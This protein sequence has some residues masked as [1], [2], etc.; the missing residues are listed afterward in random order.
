MGESINLNKLINSGVHLGHKTSRWNPKML[1][2]IFTEKNKSHIIDL[3]QTVK[4]LKKAK[5][6]LQRASRENKNILFIGTKHQASKIIIEE[7]TRCGSP[8]INYKWLGGTLTNWVTLQKRVN[9]LK[10][11]EINDN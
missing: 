2:Y 6:F 9:K 1:P 5:L 10:K 3:V 7:A 4:S 8:Y 11:L